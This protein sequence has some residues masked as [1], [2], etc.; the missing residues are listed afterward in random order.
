MLAAGNNP[1]PETLKLLVECGADV[2]GKSKDGFDALTFACSANKP[3]VVDTLIALGADVNSKD[4][5]EFTPLMT[6]SLRGDDESPRI[7]ATL[8]KAGAN[9]DEKR[10]IDQ[11]SRNGWELFD[12]NYID[13]PPWP[14]IGMPKANFLKI[15]GLNWLVKS[16]KDSVP[17]S[18][19]DY[20]SGK[21]P[22]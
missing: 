6:A 17:Y 16:G 11:L 10:I 1:N 4:N 7:I 5:Q 19:I 13:V 2:N 15:F 21:A 3:A 18:I 14:D 9:I 20:Y 8:I 22:D 12:R